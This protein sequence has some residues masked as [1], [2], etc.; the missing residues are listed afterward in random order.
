MKSVQ[1]KKGRRGDGDECGKETMEKAKQEKWNRNMAVKQM[2]NE[3][4]TRNLGR[5]RVRKRVKKK[6][7]K[8]KKR[9]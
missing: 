8:N 1:R 6:E 2:K 7:R 9:N 5:K 3:E 4:D